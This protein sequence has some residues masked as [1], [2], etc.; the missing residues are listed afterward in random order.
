MCLAAAERKTL[1]RRFNLCSRSAE[2]ATGPIGRTGPVGPTGP[3]GLKGDP[4]AP[5]SQGIAGATG[6]SGVAGPQGLR[7]PTGP[8]GVQGF[9]GPKGDPGPVGATGATGPT[10][11][12]GGPYLPLSGG[13]VEGTTFFNDQPH[14]YVTASG[15]QTVEFSSTT[16]LDIWDVVES[17]SNILY[18]AG[19]FTISVAGTYVITV[20]MISSAETN[21]IS[22]THL[23][24]LVLS[25][26]QDYTSLLNLYSTNLGEN[27][28]L[29]SNG[30][31]LGHLDEKD[32]IAVYA[33]NTNSP[34]TSS[35]NYGTQEFI[36]YGF[37]SPFPSN[38]ATAR[39]SLHM[40][41]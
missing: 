2:A 26:A 23:V 8:T 10:G 41:A 27:T 7:G 6:P 19:W 22:N 33:S 17:K 11:N 5:G 18:N 9:T 25:K 38:V 34:I 21:L 29:T 20:Q 37:P 35:V 28:T 12:T 31:W 24:A 36:A 39:I 16:V 3:T 13:T 4:G 40:I 32:Q 15:Y 14:Y 30:S 1:T